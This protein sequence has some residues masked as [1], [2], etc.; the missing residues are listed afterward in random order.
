MLVSVVVTTYNRPDALRAVLHALAAQH[1]P[2]FEVIVAD[3]GSGPATAQMLGEFERGRFA[4]GLE[5][6]LHAWQPDEGFRA[7]AARNMAVAAS[8]GS[9]LVFLDGDCVPRPDFV[10]RHRM[11][12]ERG[13]LVSGSRVLMS[14]ALTACVLA[15]GPASALH[16]RGLSYWLAQRLRGRTNKVVP[17]VRIADSPLRRYR[18]VQWRRIKSCNLGVWRSDFEA[19]DG[20]DERFVG[21]GHE[22]ADLVLRLARAGVRRKSGAFST[23]VFHLW[24][25]ENPRAL[26]S[27]NRRR[28]E[29]RFA[30][31]V[32]RAEVGLSS[33]PDPGERVHAVIG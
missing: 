21:W 15:A 27:A 16:G 19:V 8:A 24:H 1:D 9:Y 33:H 18:S 6:L 25:R 4:P 12:A 3:D 2:R 28:V 14:E 32:V 11:L 23:E 26:E 31:G 7:A 20:F 5:R 30:S 13:C 10:A 22:D 17:L 29:E